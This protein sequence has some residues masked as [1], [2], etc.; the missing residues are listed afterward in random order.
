MLFEVESTRIDGFLSRRVPEA[1]LPSLNEGP[2]LGELLG[3]GFHDNE[4]IL[5]EL[6]VDRWQLRR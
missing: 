2:L 1:D 3:I 6:R 4:L 5:L